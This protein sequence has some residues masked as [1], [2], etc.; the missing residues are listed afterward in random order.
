MTMEKSLC[1]SRYG[2]EARDSKLDAFIDT[3]RSWNRLYPEVSLVFQQPKLQAQIMCLV[4]KRGLFRDFKSVG[5]AFS[6]WT[7]F[8]HIGLR[9]SVERPTVSTYR[10]CASLSRD[11]TDKRGVQ[12]LLQL[13]LQSKKSNGAMSVNVRKDLQWCPAS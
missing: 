2:F 1:Q 9:I 3:S 13:L 8:P 11:L 7:P 5:E 12:K 4:L 10:I 6:V